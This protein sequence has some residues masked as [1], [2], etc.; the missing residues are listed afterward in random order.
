MVKAKGK[1][2]R[3]IVICRQS[4][5]RVQLN[6]YDLPHVLRESFVSHAI[7]LT[8]EFAITLTAVSW[9]VA[10]ATHGAVMA[11]NAQEMTMKI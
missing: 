1:A 6:V 3:N 9:D 5:T 11:H 8:S 2:H 7:K 4:N 10:I